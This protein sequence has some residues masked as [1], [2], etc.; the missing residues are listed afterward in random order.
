MKITEID[1]R[2]IQSHNFKLRAIRYGGT[3]DH[4]EVLEKCPVVLGCFLFRG[5]IYIRQI[6][7][8]YFELN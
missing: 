4:Y 2:V 5:R 6:D 1:K 3:I 7:R 8:T